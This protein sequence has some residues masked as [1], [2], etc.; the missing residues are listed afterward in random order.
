MLGSQVSLKLVLCVAETE[1]RARG[2]TPSARSATT[3]SRPTSRA[4]E[5]SVRKR[6]HT[7]FFRQCAPV[8]SP[9]WLLAYETKMLVPQL[10]KQKASGLGACAYGVLR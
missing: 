8:R 7:S 5:V 2:V 10:K 6:S 4:A 9:C 1:S 3:A